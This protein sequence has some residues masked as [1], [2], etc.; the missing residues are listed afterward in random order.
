[1]ELK[2][3]CGRE[4]RRFFKNRLETDKKRCKASWKELRD[5]W[6]RIFKEL[7]KESWIFFF[8]QKIK[9]R[10]LIWEILRVIVSSISVEDWQN[11]LPLGELKIILVFLCICKVAPENHNLEKATTGLFWLNPPKP[12][13]QT[14]S[15]QF[16]SRSFLISTLKV[17]Y[18]VFLSSMFLSGTF[19]FVLSTKF[20]F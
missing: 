2:E 10:M 3:G 12:N 15:Y 18:T 7:E 8:Q 1:M 13:R 11:W 20:L 6:A 9:H 19:Q 5:I 14:R 17:P 16:L 4:L